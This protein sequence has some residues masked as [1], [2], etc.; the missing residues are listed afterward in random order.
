MKSTVSQ[1]TTGFE[2]KN[3]IINLVSDVQ[4]L[5]SSDS[6]TRAG[7]T[8]STSLLLTDEG[9]QVIYLTIHSAKNLTKK[10]V[11]GK[12]DPYVSIPCLWVL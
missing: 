6:E 10:D 9:H 7:L 11:T 4:D 5:I 1:S 2:S 8:R 3:T 12:S